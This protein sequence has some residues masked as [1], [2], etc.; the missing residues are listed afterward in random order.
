MRDLTIADLPHLQRILR[1]T[2][3][4]TEA[5]VACA[6]ELL[7]IVLD[8]PAQID[9]RV[10]VA[11]TDG[12]VQGYVLYGPTPLADGNVTL[13]W[14]AVCPEAQCRGVGRRLMAQV[15]EYARQHGGRLV[16][17]ETSSQ[18]GYER[19]RRFYRQTGYVEESRIRDFYSP[20]DD[21]ITF[22]KRLDQTP[23]L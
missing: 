7:A 17:L 23:D 22:V 18:G 16:C 3:V 5:E 10:A 19:T 20:G 21:R 14:I 6:M 8:D 13:Y 2:G 9:Y 1:S 11:Q 12:D 15:E 4:F